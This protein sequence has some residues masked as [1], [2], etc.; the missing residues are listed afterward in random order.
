KELLNDLQRELQD[1]GVRA[2]SGAEE[3]AR[4]RRDELH[5][6][7]SNNRSRRNQLE[8]ALTFCEAEMENLTRK[9]RKLERDYH[10]MRGQVVT[11][12]AG[13][14][15]VMRMVKDNGVERRLHRRDLA[16]LWG[17]GLGSV[18]VRGLGALRLGVAGNGHVRVV[19]R[20]SDDP[21]R[22]E[23]KIQLF[24]AVYQP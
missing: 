18:L 8:K 13:W 22:P 24:V 1:I 11:A 6:Q 5:A 17:D 2:D 7:L 20:L 23:G 12:K 16:Y 4:Q 3:R 15:A 19:V 9:L 10:E 14:C 21:K